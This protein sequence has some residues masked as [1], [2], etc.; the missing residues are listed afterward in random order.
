[1]TKPIVELHP[2]HVWTCDECG[3]DNFVRAIV[4]EPL[5]D[6][7][8]GL[9]ESAG[10]DRVDYDE[11]TANPANGGVFTTMPGSVACDH[12]KAEFGVDPASA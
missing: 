10:I 7:L 9:L 2:A 1:M 8:D 12:C 6:E 11:W 4:Y 3:R 5:E